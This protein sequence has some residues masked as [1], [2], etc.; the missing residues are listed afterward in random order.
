MFVTAKDEDGENRD[1]FVWASTMDEAKR[2]FQ[3]TF[4][5]P[6]EPSGVFEIDIAPP[7]APK[8]LLWHVDV[9]PLHLHE[10]ALR[11]RGQ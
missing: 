1:L 4:E 2:L 8:A 7:A 3:A 10:E 6:T 9:F 5:L 11:R